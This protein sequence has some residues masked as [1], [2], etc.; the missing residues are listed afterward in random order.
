MVL[1][2]GG[3]RGIQHARWS[4]RRDS[5]GPCVILG[6]DEVTKVFAVADYQNPAG[7]KLAE[8]DRHPAGD[9]TG[10]AERSIAHLK[11]WRIT[12]RYR[13]DL[14]RIDTDIQAVVDRQQLNQHTSGHQLTYDR[15]KRAALPK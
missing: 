5:I 4:V 14:S 3:Q 15:I 1:E 8:P 13:S 12:T 2:E 10:A 7:G 11:N 9:A 6:P